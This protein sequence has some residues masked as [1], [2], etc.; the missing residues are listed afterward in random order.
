MYACI[1]VCNIIYMCV[2]Y[3]T[4]YNGKRHKSNTNTFIT[5]LYVGSV[6]ICTYISVFGC[7][8]KTFSNILTRM[9]SD[10]QT[11]PPLGGC[12]FNQISS[13]SAEDYFH[14]CIHTYIHSHMQTASEIARTTG[15]KI[16]IEPGL[17][18]GPG[19]VP[20]W[21]P[22]LLERYRYLGEFLTHKIHIY[23]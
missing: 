17:A 22:D 12:I 15:A 8:R 4:L 9:F 1:L 11:A 3:R 14:A 20:G 21:L 19:H 10:M 23:W 2:C 7:A 18:E 5:C 13:L 6:D 16:L